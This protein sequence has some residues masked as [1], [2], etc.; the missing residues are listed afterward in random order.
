MK[1]SLTARY[2]GVALSMPPSDQR[3]HTTR[4]SPRISVRERISPG[5]TASLF[6]NYR[7]AADA[8]ME[9]VDNALDS[10]RH[11]EVQDID[12][13]I[14][15]HSLI[16]MSTGGTGM[17]PGDFQRHYLNWGASPKRGQ[18][19]L[20]QYGQGGKAAIGFLGSRFTLEASR[21]GET[22]GWR[23]GDPDYRSR[24]RL[25]TYDVERVPR[26]AP[27]EVA[28]VRIR[29]DG[30]DKRVDP[31]RLEPRLAECYRPLLEAGWLR[32]TLNARQLR[33]Q[34]LDA[35]ARRTFRVRAAGRLVA[36]WFGIRDE[37]AAD[38][39]FRCYRL[40]RLVASG[41]FFGHP[42]PAQAPGLGRLVGEVE[43][44]VVAL[45]MNKS[46]FDRDSYAWSAIE[47]RLHRL[48]APTVKRLAREDQQPP[49]AA[50]LRAADQARRLLSRAL[51]LTE[52]TELFP[53]LEQ[54]RERQPT[55][56]AGDQL[57]LE[58]A[59]QRLTPRA[60]ER[61]PPGAGPR[62]RGFGEIVLKPLDPAIRSQTVV[63]AGVNRIVINTRYPL[64]VERKGDTWYQLQTAVREICRGAEP[65]DV[66]DYERRVSSLLLTAF[67]LRPAGRRR[68]PAGRQLKLVN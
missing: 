60:A 42:V 17:G 2:N 35:P 32:L 28:Y 31:G 20:G 63:E 34:P 58:E 15:P 67:K 65:T 33:A 24:S 5:I 41:E 54:G 27:L 57:L 30:I 11:G 64:F 14:Q 16:V 53:G 7:S 59:R 56:D 9:L 61:R 23:I 8:V 43:I 21:A 13:A 4:G 55:P 38:A 48:L 37:P 29:I 36:G 18:N 52:S 66:A 25:K 68:P 19:K 49:P 6:A 50:A 46:D 62:R 40:G 1:S 3:V 26:R 10:R 51:R 47:A 39:G 44:P 22:E 12:V 45:T